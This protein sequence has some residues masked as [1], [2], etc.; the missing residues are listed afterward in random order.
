MKFTQ[1]NHKVSRPKNSTVPA[2]AN[3]VVRLRSAMGLTQVDFA[4]RL[5]TAS[6]TVARWETGTVEPRIGAVM[7]MHHLAKRHNVT[8]AEAVFHSAVVAAVPELHRE[9][10]NITKDHLAEALHL[11]GEALHPLR[12]HAANPLVEAA[13][14]LVSE[15]L[16]LVTALDPEEA[17]KIEVSLVLKEGGANQ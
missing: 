14:N 1:A 16:K 10:V 17:T 5:G 12:G 13:G 4:K 3:A 7:D 11:L 8:A 6:S 15:A 2:L 9:A